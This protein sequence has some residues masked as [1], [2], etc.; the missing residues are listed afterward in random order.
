[1]KSTPF[2][3]STLTAASAVTAAIAALTL[4]ACGPHDNAETALATPTAQAQPAATST[5][6]PAPSAAPLATNPVPPVPMQGTPVPPA[7]VQPAYPAQ[8]SY[9][10][11]PTSNGY[12]PQPNYV[13]ERPE[14]V[15]RSRI[16]SVA[17]IEPIRERPQGTGAGAVIGG[18]LGAVVGNQFGHGAGRAGMT[19]VGAVGGAIAGNNLERNHR[20]AITGYRVSIRLDNGTTRSF[21]R[22][23][24]GGLQ[25]GDRVRVDAGTFRRV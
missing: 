6:P 24:V 13:A 5:A 7:A 17:S 16:G 18:V 15:D 4:T 20:E 11:Q 14:A 22:S 3:P 12:A 9:P 19:G 25:V 8:S 21:E 23:Q 2:K 1:M 10:V